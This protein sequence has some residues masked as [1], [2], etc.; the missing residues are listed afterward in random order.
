MKKYTLGF[1]LGLTLSV[2]MSAQVAAQ[3]PQLRDDIP[4]TYTVVR[5]DTLWDISSTYLKNPWMW[6]EIWH[7]NT[8]IENPHLIYPG[9]VIRLIYLDGQPRLTVVNRQGPVMKLTPE[10]RVLTEAE[11]INTIA[12][13]KINSFL[14]RSRVVTDEELKLAPYI[15]SGMDEHLIAGAGDSVYARGD[16]V[17]HEAVYGIYRRGD[18]Y[19]DPETGEKLGVQALD[20][21]S[22]EIRSV[23][24]D[25]GTMRLSR[26]REEIR[27]GDRL[28]RQEERPI[29][30]TFFPSP[31]VGDVEGTILAVEGGLT[32]VGKLDV[33]VINRGSREGM[34][35]GNVLAMYKR[36]NK[37][38]D[39]VGGGSVQLPDERAGLLMVFRSFEKVS[40]ALILEAERGIAVNDKVRN[41]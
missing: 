13:D 41:P 34:T 18:V 6:P 5:G 9:D 19:K 35:P 21:G 8:Q 37:I 12:L 1:F 30:S 36:G 40:L 7:V 33:V 4:D 14:S 26:S 16:F 28:L 38:K 29:D 10:A 31:P 22:G 39:R 3:G 27:I 25:V 17:D 24:G 20:I 15:V 23:E 2:L 32:Q 11:A